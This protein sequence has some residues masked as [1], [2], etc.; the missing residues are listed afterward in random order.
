MPYRDQEESAR[1]RLAERRRAWE[2]DRSTLH[3]ELLRIY[4]RRTARVAAGRT[5]FL[6]FVALFATACPD[7]GWATMVLAAAWLAVRFVSGCA[8]VVARVR[9]RRALDRHERSGDDV[10]AALDA[11]EG[12]TPEGVVARLARRRE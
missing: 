1:A 5:A 4:G 12:T 2:E 8:R 6:G 3:P 9:V 7:R 10:W 11:R